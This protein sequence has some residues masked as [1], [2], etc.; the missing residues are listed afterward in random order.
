VQEPIYSVYHRTNPPSLRAKEGSPRPKTVETEDLTARS[1]EVPI[2]Q[3]KPAFLACSCG[4][5]V[6][7]FQRICGALRWG[8][9]VFARAQVGDLHV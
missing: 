7:T 8:V 9:G 2:H 6:Q 3:T 1:L 4:L 5:R